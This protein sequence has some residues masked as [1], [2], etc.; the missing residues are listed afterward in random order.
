M[1]TRRTFL[2]KGAAALGAATTGCN[3]LP[4]RDNDAL[5]SVAAALAAM[6]AADPCSPEERGQQEEQERQKANTLRGFLSVLEMHRKTLLYKLE[7]AL[8]LLSDEEKDKEKTITVGFDGQAIVFTLK[9]DENVKGQVSIALGKRQREYLKDGGKLIG[10]A[11]HVL[12]QP[13]PLETIAR[14]YAEKEFDRFLDKHLKPGERRLAKEVIRLG[15]YALQEEENQALSKYLTGWT[16]EQI[17]SVEGKLRRPVDKVIEKGREELE[18]VE[19]RVVREMERVEKRALKPA[20]HLLDQA[21][22]PVSRAVHWVERQADAVAPP[23]KE[24]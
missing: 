4:R 10:Q 20:H 2:R 13:E 7:E 18:R 17:A 12:R 16:Q 3:A 14:E 22:R 11:L 5:D 23:D 15:G 21:G 24:R 8:K 6:P 19:R 1:D 9:V